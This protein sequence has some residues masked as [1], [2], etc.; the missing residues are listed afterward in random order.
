MD[1]IEAIAE[2]L[3]T[4][5]QRASDMYD[6][7]FIISKVLQGNYP[8]FRQK[9]AT[10]AAAQ[11]ALQLGELALWAQREADSLRRQE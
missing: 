8:V 7:L 10:A 1:S 4:M 6:R 3:A 9:T 5:S 11:A 2:E